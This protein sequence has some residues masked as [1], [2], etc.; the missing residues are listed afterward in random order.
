MASLKGI[1]NEILH[2]GPSP[3]PGTEVGPQPGL[4]NISPCPAVPGGT[5]IVVEVPCDVKECLES[6]L[7]AHPDFC[8]FLNMIIDYLALAEGLRAELE[9]LQTEKENINIIIEALQAEIDN[10]NNTIDAIQTVIAELGCDEFYLGSEGD[11][12]VFGEEVDPICVSYYRALLKLMRE[13]AEKQGYIDQLK[14][15]RAEIL[16][17][18]ALLQ[19]VLNTIEDILIQMQQTY[20]DQI[21]EAASECRENQKPGDQDTKTV[22]T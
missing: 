20:S 10:I 1:L 16:E 7:A 18:M 12:P 21:H 19:E 15:K 14:L 8:T 3:H 11:E 13:K 17:D 4:C 22:V 2:G 6:E 9:E 5:A